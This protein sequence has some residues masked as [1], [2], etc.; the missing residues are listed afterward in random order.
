MFYPSWMRHYLFMFLL[1]N[2]NDISILVKNNKAGAKWLLELMNYLVVPWSIAA[3]YISRK[4]YAFEKGKNQTFFRY[5]FGWVLVEFYQSVT[6][7][8]RK[9]TD[10]RETGRCSKPLRSFF[11]CLSYLVIIILLA[12]RYILS[13]L[14][15]SLIIWLFIFSL[16]KWR[17]G[18]FQSNVFIHSLKSCRIEEV[19]VYEYFLSY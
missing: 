3:Q 6:V 13:S 10:E 1:S 4:W 12:I 7:D 15:Q 18:S 2:T 9:R 11:V 16:L 14:F 5:P 8:G 19:G 17:I